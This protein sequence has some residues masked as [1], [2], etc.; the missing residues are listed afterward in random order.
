MGD[1][2]SSFP[3]PLQNSALDKIALHHKAKMMALAM[4][5]PN[6]EPRGSMVL[7]DSERALV[8]EVT[9]RAE[10]E[11][12]KQTTTADDETPQELPPRD[13]EPTETAVQAEDV[14]KEP[15]TLAVESPHAISQP[16]PANESSPV[17]QAVSTITDQRP[18]KRVR[19]SVAE[20]AGY[21]ALGGVLAWSAL[22]ATAPVL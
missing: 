1:H 21:V 18:V 19:R 11:E 6:Q 3:R 9:A 8:E 17:V 13:T 12:A 2:E 10:A 22:V 15:T 5:A 7:S 20:A 16:E 14:S 4:R